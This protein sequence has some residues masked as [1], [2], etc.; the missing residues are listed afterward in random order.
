[1]TRAGVR[2]GAVALPRGYGNDQEEELAHRSSGAAHSGY[3]RRGCPRGML[4]LSDVSTRSA[5]A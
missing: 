4:C 5:S 2:A 1:M 3:R